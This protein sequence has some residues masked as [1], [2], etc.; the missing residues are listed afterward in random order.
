MAM[1]FNYDQ[2]LEHV[3]LNGM[4]DASMDDGVLD[5][6]EV[7][8]DSPIGMD[9]DVSAGSCFVGN[10]K[11]TESGITNVSISTAHAS[12]AR[13]DIIIYD[14]SAGAPIV[15]DGTAAAIPEP[16]DIPASDII[17]ALVD[18]QAAVSSIS[19]TDITDKRIIVNRV[20]E[21]VELQ[22]M[23][24][25]VKYWAVINDLD[26]SEN[27]TPDMSVD[28]SSGSCQI[29]ETIYT[30]S[31]TT[32]VSIT[33]ADSTY[34]RRDIIIYDKSA[35]NPAAIDGVAS[36]HPVAPD[37]P[38]EDILLAIVNVPANATTI[39]NAYITDKRIVS[40][41][42]DDMCYVN[43]GGY[44]GDG[45]VNRA[46]SHGLGRTPKFVIFGRGDGYYRSIVYS[47]SILYTT[48]TYD[49]AYTVTGWDST[50]FYVGAAGDMGPS[51]NQNT[52]T[53]SW[54]AFG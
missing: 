47:G 3:D 15:V 37:L 16:P 8:E 45:T 28:V 4:I 12:Y 19:N 46:I 21:Y 52:L 17:L 49:S 30:E 7:G 31:G 18:V 10:V 14:T 23:V 24:R 35:G 38:D 51:N 44:T 29:D 1:D 54:T 25:A 11:Y 43:N 5:G 2:V 39:I 22:N 27:G 36:A 13:K 34:A 41:I 9:V 42:L 26:V 48:A 32:N 40:G 53:Y 6:L 20:L 50:Y 33:A